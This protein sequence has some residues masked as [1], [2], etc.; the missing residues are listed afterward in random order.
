M[1][2]FIVFISSWLLISLISLNFTIKL[3]NLAGHTIPELTING[4]QLWKPGAD[5]VWVKGGLGEIKARYRINRDGWNSIIDY[6]K[7]YPDSQKIA[8]IGDSYIEGF[9]VDAANSIGRQFEQLSELS[10]RVHEYGKSGGNIVDFSKIYKEYNLDRFK[11]VFVFVT[12]EDLFDKRAAFM[13]VSAPA[14]NDGLFRELYAAIPLLRYLNIN[15]GLM[16]NL[17]NLPNKPFK[18]INADQ[19]S[20]AEKKIKKHTIN[21]DALN[22]FNINTIFIYERSLLSDTLL[23][24][25]PHNSV[26]INPVLLPDN[27]GFDKHWNINGRKNCAIAIY[28]YL[29]NNN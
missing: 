15:H 1:S 11:K 14:A 27:Y 16:H 4:N 13:R 18:N 29:N 20:K 17:K 19:G 21:T 10:Y 23:W 12:D 7:D 25:L 22:V 5:S 2:K 8:I 6:Q 9:H 3:F 24:Q 28:Q 26:A